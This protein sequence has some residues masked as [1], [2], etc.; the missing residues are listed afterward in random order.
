[1]PLVDN[2]RGSSTIE[3]VMRKVL[4]VLAMALAAAASPALSR[5]KGSPDMKSRLDGTWEL[6][7]G[8]P[9]P[10]GTRDIKILSGGHF[11][12]AAYDLQTGKPLYAAGGTYVLDG[13]SYSEHLDFGT[14]TL[15][16]LVGKNQSFTVTVRRDSFTQTGTLTN[17]KPLSEVWKRAY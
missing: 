4:L 12:F 5:T 1:V 2:D 17:G 11:M 3:D 7:S 8:Q 10:N 13:N 15:A 14:D 16:A 9:L 6:L